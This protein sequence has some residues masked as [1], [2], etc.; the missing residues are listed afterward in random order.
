[1]PVEKGEH[2]A[3]SETHKPSHEQH[4]AV[5]HTAKQPDQVPEAEGLRVAGGGRCLLRGL[6]GVVPLHV[7]DL[8][9]F[10]FTFTVFEVAVAEP[11]LS[12]NNQGHGHENPKD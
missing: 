8:Y 7:R 9:L 12:S 11:E 2:E 1:M 3:I 6:R 5:L 10:P 4:G